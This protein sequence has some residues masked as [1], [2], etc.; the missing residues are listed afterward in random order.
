MRP[1]KREFSSSR[2]EMNGL[3]G[4]WGQK[5]GDLTCMLHIKHEF[6]LV[7]NFQQFNNSLFNL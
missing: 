1:K 6:Y 3:G 5:E 7:D 4:R 2:S